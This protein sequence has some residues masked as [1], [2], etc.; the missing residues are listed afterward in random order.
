MGGG[1]RT[2]PEV[3]GDGAE[4]IYAEQLVERRV[5]WVAERGETVMGGRVRKG[6]QRRCR[7]GYSGRIG[8][9]RGPGRNGE[10]EARAG[11]LVRTLEAM[12]VRRSFGLVLEAAGSCSGG[13]GSSF[14]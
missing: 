8:D 12:W 13:M 1:W 4:V 7:L 6:R 11:C 5:G 3:A 10:D 9:Q 14:M 2:A